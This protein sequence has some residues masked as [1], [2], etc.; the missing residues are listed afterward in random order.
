MH[1]IATLLAAFSLLGIASATPVSRDVKMCYPKQ[2]WGAG[3]ANI[4]LEKNNLE[5]WALN[6]TVAHG[7]VSRV[8]SVKAVCTLPNPLSL[9]LKV[10]SPT[11]PLARPQH[12]N[13]NSYLTSTPPFLNIRPIDSTVE[14]EL[15]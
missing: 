12:T 8:Y 2:T 3:R 13:T 9:R 11:L 1:S 4:L 10:S 14:Y 15:Q 6:A 7:K 5:R